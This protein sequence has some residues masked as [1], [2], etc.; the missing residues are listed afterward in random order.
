MFFFSG[1]TT[2]VLPYIHQWLSGPYFFFFFFFS[3]NIALNGFWQFFL[4]LPNFWAKT[5]GVLKKRIW[6][7][8]VRGVYPPYTLSGPTTKENTFL[9]VSSL[10]RAVQKT[11]V[12]IIFFLISR[13]REATRL[14]NKEFFRPLRGKTFYFYILD[15]IILETRSY[16]DL[17]MDTGTGDFMKKGTHSYLCPQG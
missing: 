14:R 16:L 8:V 13:L 3:Y 7:L 11:S 15:Y 9:C 17:Q 1:R 2:K 5:A 4:F 12:N 10:R 6:C